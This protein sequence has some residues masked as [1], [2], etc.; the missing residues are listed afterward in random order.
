MRIIF[1]GVGGGRHMMASQER[2]TS[3]IYMNIGGHSFVLD[4]GPGSM[5]HAHQVGIS[6]QQL[7]GVL[8]SHV[9]ID[10]TSDA[11]CFLDGISIKTKPW[12]IAEEHC[13]QNH[14]VSRYHQA[15]SNVYPVKPGT[16]LKLSD[17]EITATKAAHVDPC[18]GF[19]IKHGKFKLGYASDGF[20]FPGQ[21]KQ[22]EDCDILILNTILPKGFELKPEFGPK[23]HMT[24][25]DA[26]T[27]LRSIKNKPKLTVIQHYSMF[28]IR[29]NIFKQAKILK[30]ATKCDVIAADDFMEINENLKSNILK[31]R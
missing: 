1:L 24:I 25:D 12:I 30:D 27:L 15:L 22:Y 7:H 16:K 31:P 10:H 28:M 23:R 8:L 13:I 2:H 29:A 21:E 20:Y 6:P 18:V 17:L 14:S 4:P 11:N 26:I 9:H 19:V 5:I 3:G